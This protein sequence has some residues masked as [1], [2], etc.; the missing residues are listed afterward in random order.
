MNPQ[1]LA[2]L[3]TCHIRDLQHLTSQ[4]PDHSY[5]TRPKP[6]RG[7]G[8]RSRLRSKIGSALVEAGLHLLAGSADAELGR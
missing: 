1:L 6:A 8:R 2:D 7:N 3:V 5:L 4:R